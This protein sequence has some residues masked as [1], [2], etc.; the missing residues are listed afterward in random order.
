MN[1]APEQNAGPLT[2]IR[3]LDFSHILAGPF[4]AMILTDFGADV[5]KVE[6]P[7]GGDM[8]RRTGGD[9]FGTYFASIHRGKRGIILD[10]KKPEAVDIAR[11]MAAK[12]D[13]LIQN[14]A[15]GSFDRM[16]L[17]Y[18]AL[19]AT[20]PGLVYAAVS[21]FGQDGPW[22]DRVGAD[23]L[24]QPMSGLMSITG[25]KDGQPVRVGYTASDIAA[26]SWLAIAILGA[27]Y[28]RERSGKGQFIDISLLEAQMALMEN[29][30][31]RT[32]NGG[33][34]AIRYGSGRHLDSTTESYE[35]S[36]GWFITEFEND[37]W[38]AVCRLFGHPEWPETEGLRQPEHNPVA[39]AA[40]R[41]VLRT[42]PVDYWVQ[43]FSGQ[44]DSYD[45]EADRPRYPAIRIV[46]TVAQAVELP[47]I[48]ERGFIQ[49]T[50]DGEGRLF[51]IAGSPLRL[52]RT[53]GRVRGP[54][55]LLGEH[56]RDALK[57]WIDIEDAEFESLEALEVFKAQPT[58]HRT[59]RRVLYY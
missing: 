50:I 7:A 39:E 3:V 16:G 24:I 36:D 27:L 56:T 38:A 37:T 6:Q 10:L 32:L 47:P 52:S 26:G 30:I 54:A 2:G 14:Y 35:A 22:A 34:P 45:T 23:A 33:E 48:Q 19:S 5:V 12:A 29:P 57:D 1:E 13:V 46:N 11:R 21:A 8:G 28:E 4:G 42:Q 25:Q 15:P 59:L 49:E 40:I 55:P 43:L 17:G 41:E 58:Q 20:N 53:P 9:Q 31:V 51:R 44:D 18:E